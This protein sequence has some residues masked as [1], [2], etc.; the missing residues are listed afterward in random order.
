MSSKSQ[1]SKPLLLGEDQVDVVTDVKSEE[2]DDDDEVTTQQNPF[3]ILQNDADA[4]TPQSPR[5]QRFLDM[6]EG[7]IDHAHLD[8]GEKELETWINDNDADSSDSSD[9]SDD[10][11]DENHENDQKDN[12]K[13]RQTGMSEEEILQTR[14][15]LGGVLRKLGKEGYSNSDEI[16]RTISQI[17]NVDKTNVVNN[18]GDHVVALGSTQLTTQLVWNKKRLVELLGKQLK[19][20]RKFNVDLFTNRYKKHRMNLNNIK[21]DD[22]DII[23]LLG[24]SGAGKSTTIHYL[25][26]SKMEKDPDNEGHIRA[27]NVTDPELCEIDTSFKPTESV[28]RY[29]TPVSLI[30]DSNTYYLCD[31]PGFSDTS[32]FS[33]SN[34]EISIANRMGLIYTM[35]IARKFVVLLILSSDDMANKMNSFKNVS[36][37]VKN[38]LKYY[39]AKDPRLTKDSGSG[40]IEN[41]GFNI[42]V[43]KHIQPILTKFSTKDKAQVKFKQFCKGSK[44]SNNKDNGY[45][46]AKRIKKANCEDLILIEPLSADKKDDVLNQIFSQIGDYWIAGGLSS[47]VA[48]ET[49]N[50]IVTRDIVDEKA[51]DLI[52]EQCKLYYEQ[53]KKIINMDDYGNLAN[54]DFSLVEKKLDQLSQL[55]YIFKGEKEIDEYL[56]KSV[57][58]VAKAW[59]KLC[60]DGLEKLRLSSTRSVFV[61]PVNG[62][63]K[64]KRSSSIV[65][66]LDAFTAC[67]AEIGVI[68]NVSSEYQALGECYLRYNKE[69]IAI[70]TTGDI[71]REVKHLFNVLQQQ[72]ALYEKLDETV[73]RIVKVEV[74]V[75]SIS[76][77]RNEF[78][79][80]IDGL[81]A[82]IIDAIKNDSEFEHIINYPQ[83]LDH[84]QS[85]L[86]SLSGVAGDH[87]QISQRQNTTM[88]K[89]QQVCVDL[90]NFVEKYLNEQ[91]AAIENKIR[92]IDVSVEERIEQCKIPFGILNAAKQCVIS[93]SRSSD[94]KTREMVLHICDK[95]DKVFENI[96]LDTRSMIQTELKTSANASKWDRIKQFIDDMSI[97]LAMKADYTPLYE[98]EMKEIVSCIMNNL[99]KDLSKYDRTNT[100]KLYQHIQWIKEYHVKYNNNDRHNFEDFVDNY[101]VQLRQYVE[102]MKH[103]CEETP[104][105]LDNVDG[106]L[107]QIRDIVRYISDELQFIMTAAIVNSTTPQLRPR[108]DTV[109]NKER[110]ESGGMHMGVPTMDGHPSDSSHTYDDSLHF[111]SNLIE[112]SDLQALIVESITKLSKRIT[113]I[114]KN[115]IDS[116]D[117]DVNR[118]QKEDTRSTLAYLHKLRNKHYK[119]IFGNESNQIIILRACGANITSLDNDWNIDFLVGLMVQENWSMGDVIKK[120]TQYLNKLILDQKKGKEKDLK[121]K[122]QHSSVASRIGR[123][124]HRRMRARARNRPRTRR[125]GFGQSSRSAQATVSRQSPT[126]PQSPATPATPGTVSA[127]KTPQNESQR[128]SMSKAATKKLL[129]GLDDSQQISA[130]VTVRDDDIKEDYKQDAMHVDERK[131]ERKNGEIEFDESG[132]ING[133]LV[134]LA[135]QLNIILKHLDKIAYYEE[136]LVRKYKFHQS[137]LNVIRIE[138]GIDDEIKFQENELNRLVSVEENDFK[139]L[140]NDYYFLWGYIYI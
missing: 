17:I 46:F 116:N 107:E 86:T 39:I 102:E 13:T 140:E 37:E 67:V 110:S 93:L 12:K 95:A 85:V 133:N 55:S 18:S 22:K 15:Q 59:K 57:L 50:D 21:K 139:Q 58:V 119:A 127:A 126:S 105:N 78:Y 34:F 53:I 125:F 91:V 38:L 124:K 10:E 26:G 113:D 36:I 48:D 66:N 104:I 62:D 42:D 54:I 44:Q 11:N 111:D 112:I 79:Q 7:K 123:M 94:T 5:R 33:N 120:C 137:K 47:G 1:E 60:N 74:M 29:I 121:A 135:E 100:P 84:A 28:T 136:T 40:D 69:N 73:D 109:M 138:T 35:N 30:Y 81:Q 132:N 19:S 6:I 82:A 108:N 134:T 49:G 72:I 68:C 14:K 77:W 97:V 4:Y 9:S 114:I 41:D 101:F 64:I 71:R 76:E 32:L 23:L 96:L 103:E 129:S 63:G 61:E 8:D 118:T 45:K 99:T 83:M 27:V 130:V 75:R 25:K 122:K 20:I 16:F 98:R 65:G 131:D 89:L 128:S 80:R 52:K 70:M 115:V 24:S 117:F 106:S 43:S 31:A 92:E 3:L 51:L 90:F 88:N 56:D 87:S 2:Q